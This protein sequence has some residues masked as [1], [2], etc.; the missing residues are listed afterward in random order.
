MKPFG[1]IGQVVSFELVKSYYPI[2][3]LLIFTLVDPVFHFGI[4]SPFTLITYFASNKIV[5]PFETIVFFE[6]NWNSA[7]QN[8]KQHNKFQSL[9]SK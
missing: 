4:S 3:P 7:V 5:S 9:I 1:R 2:V 6:R 8:I